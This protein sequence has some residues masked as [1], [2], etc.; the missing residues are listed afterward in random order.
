MGRL[1]IF[2]KA[3]VLIRSRDHNPPHFHVL[4]P[5]F[6]ALVGIEPLMILRGGMPRSVWMQ[7]QA[8]AVENHAVLIAEWNR[9]NPRFPM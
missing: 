3:V 2:G 6:E 9:V 8:W 1:A 4:A 5:D 7:V